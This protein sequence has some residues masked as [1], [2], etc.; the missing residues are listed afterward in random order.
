MTRP[1]ELL[2][3]EFTIKTAPKRPRYLGTRISA[4]TWSV[5]VWDDGHTNYRLSAAGGI[6]DY[7]VADGATLNEVFG[8]IPDWVPLPPWGWLASLDVLDRAVG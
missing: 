2:S 3:L 1:V 6:H 7:Y 4:V 8:L 5:S